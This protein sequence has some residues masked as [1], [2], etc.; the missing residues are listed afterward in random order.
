MSG[1]TFYL[2]L[3]ANTAHRKSCIIQQRKAIDVYIVGTIDI[4]IYKYI[5]EDI[6]TD[7]VIITDKQLLHIQ[8]KHPEAYQDAIGFIN[9]ILQEP[10]YIIKDDKHEN[11][12]LIVKRIS[13]GEDS[14]LIAL[15]LC[16]SQDIEGY[17]NSVIT[18]WKISERRLNNYLRNKKIL[19]KKE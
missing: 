7:E 19:Y 10:D 11:T 4:N 6:V 1:Y 17:K 3:Y 2:Y 8:E 15:K 9:G 5:T 16:T 13:V 14:I 18:S 12:G